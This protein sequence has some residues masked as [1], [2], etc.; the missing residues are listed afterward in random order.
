MLKYYFFIL[1]FVFLASCKSKQTNVD[2]TNSNTTNV[3]K[4][5]SFFELLSTSHSN[6]K[7]H[8][9]IVIESAEELNSIYST[10]NMTRRPGY[11]IPTINF[12]THT[13]IGL[14]MGLKDTGGHSIKIDSIATGNKETVIYCKAISPKDVTTSI[15]THPCYIASI[16]KTDKPIRFEQ[17]K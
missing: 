4:K 13:V 16:I 5:S 17:V 6:I 10:I 14:F 3:T 1:F 8:N 15:I 7:E 12:N 2:T 9:F 11:K